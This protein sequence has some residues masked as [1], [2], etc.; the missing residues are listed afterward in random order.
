MRNA[1]TLI[2]W[3]LCLAVCLSARRAPASPTKTV[4]LAISDDETCPSVEA[5]ED[6]LRLLAPQLQL[7]PQGAAS[8]VSIRV[9]DVG[10]SYDVRVGAVIRS[11]DD[12]DRRCE[13]RARTTAVIAAMI[14]DPP[15]LGDVD[16]PPPRPAVAPAPPSL[17]RY[18]WALIDRPLVA[19]RGIALVR[20][21]VTMGVIGDQPWLE[22]AADVLGFELGVGR[23]VQ[24]G[25][26]LAFP[27]TRFPGQGTVL[28]SVEVDISR[29]A[30]FRFEGGFERASE[31]SD[32][33]LK[34]TNGGFLSVGFP[35]RWKLSRTV[36]ITG[37]GG[38]G[39]RSQWLVNY[40]PAYSSFSP[41]LSQGLFAIRFSASS[42]PLYSV[43][44]PVG[45]LVQAHR[46][47]A[48]HLQTGVRASFAA[49]SPTA[50][51]VPVDLD[52][53]VTPHPR[54]DLGVS[55]DLAGAT[56]RAAIDY[57]TLMSLGVFLRVRI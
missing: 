27:L 46:A 49:L 45:L 36:A 12:P 34:D 41:F 54:I 38:S 42:P 19:P 55:F 47:I 7:V 17:A 1:S 28:A 9:E 40:G 48:L 6:A 43:F 56:T 10:A 15:R 2:I 32:T 29:H 31:P 22:G 53:V 11:M 13:D 18:P 35:A 14:L 39:L 21:E 20:E 8:E 57:A 50:I 26:Q 16:P 23:G 3:T 5:V 51:F 44:L 4:G 33:L 30:A 24:I 25:A 37:G 52:V